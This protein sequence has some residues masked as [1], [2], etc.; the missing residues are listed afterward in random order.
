MHIDA[1]N[2]SSVVCIYSTVTSLCSW[3]QES[4]S[5]MCERGYEAASKVWNG[6]DILVIFH[7]LGITADTFALLKV[8][9]T[10]LFLNLI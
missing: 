7:S 1:F 2:G 9:H 5:L 4:R 6:K 10:S 3:I 8:H